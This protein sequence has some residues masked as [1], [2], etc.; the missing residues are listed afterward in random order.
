[1][2]INEDGENDVF[3]NSGSMTNSAGISNSKYHTDLESRK[4]NHKT[5]EQNLMI[6]TPSFLSTSNNIMLDNKNF[7]ED[8]INI[9]NISKKRNNQNEDNINIDNRDIK[10]ST[11]SNYSHINNSKNSIK[12][13]SKNIFDARIFSDD[14]MSIK[15]SSKFNNSNNNEQ[16]I[17]NLQNSST[18]SLLLSLNINEIPLEDINNNNDESD[19]LKN[20]I[21]KIIPIDIFNNLIP[22]QNQ[23]I[24]N[25]REGL[26]KLFIYLSD[27]LNNQKK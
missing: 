5:T 24:T 6:N 17:N 14:D 25:T 2:D 20:E 9:N 13:N 7:K 19:N 27:S 16:N 3:V 4:K 15:K 11:Y 26:K 1:M 21:K 8:N 22:S 18:N 10:S 12:H 23:L